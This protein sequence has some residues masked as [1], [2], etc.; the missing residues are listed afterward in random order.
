MAQKREYAERLQAFP[1]VTQLLKTYNNSYCRKVASIFE[2]SDIEKFLTMELDT[3][4][5]LVRK[6]V[7]AIALSGGLRCAEIRD[8]EISNLEEKGNSYEVT[9]IRKKQ[10]GEKIQSMFIVPSSLAIYVKNYLVALKAVFGEDISG[11]LIKGTPKW[12]FVNQPMGKNLLASIGKNVADILK[13]DN[14]ES[15]TGHCF[16]RTAVVLFH[17]CYYFSNVS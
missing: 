10:Q 13:L 16:R 4:Y 15:F 6:A 2:R 12:R 3:P 8:I 5:W 17:K 7:V 14:P 11:P 1:R 9:L